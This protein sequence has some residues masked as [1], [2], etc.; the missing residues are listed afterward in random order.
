[1][2]LGCHLRRYLLWNLTSRLARRQENPLEFQGAKGQ[3]PVKA[4]GAC[5]SVSYFSAL[6]SASRFAA[7]T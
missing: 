6:G 3:R 7:A 5:L 2:K 1:M 4:C